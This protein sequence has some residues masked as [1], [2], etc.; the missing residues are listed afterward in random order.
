MRSPHRKER[1][2]A[3]VAASALL[4][5]AC[6]TDEDTE[7]EVVEKD[8]TAEDSALEIAGTDFAFSGIPATIAAGT[9]LKFRNDSDKEVH[10]VVALKISD[11]ETRPLAD[12]LKLSEEEL[13]SL[14]GGP[15]AAVLVAA[16]GE[17]GMAVVGDGTLTD[18]G[19]YGFVCM[20]VMV[21]EIW[22][23]AILSGILSTA[24]A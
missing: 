5:G 2:L 6:A 8:A 16:P 13:D 19:R 12:L 9:L 4:L 10:E 3:L 15:P 11:S 17:A 21:H 14:L 18:P 22:L 24:S 20:I 7:R 23:L 1:I